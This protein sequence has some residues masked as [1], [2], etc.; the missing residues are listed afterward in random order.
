MLTLHI[1]NGAS[2]S[3]TLKHYFEQNK[4]DGTNQVLC[5]DDYLAIGPL[6]DG[7]KVNDHQLLN[8]RANYLFDM[9]QIA[10]LEEFADVNVEDQWLVDITEDISK[11][12]HFD[13]TPYH[14][15]VI[16][17]GDNAPERSLLYL[18]CHIIDEHKLYH[19]S[20]NDYNLSTH[21]LRGVGD[22]SLEMLDFLHNQEKKIYPVDCV[23]YSQLWQTL[24]KSS[25]R[26]DSL[27]RIFESNEVKSVGEDY[28]DKQILM[29]CQEQGQ[30]QGQGNF[31]LM[32]ALVGR[33]LGLSEQL[34]TDTFIIARVYY[35]IQN[36]S[37]GY[38]GDLDQPR[39]LQVRVRD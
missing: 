5:F 21:M 3:G 1:V 39:Q 23:Q 4:L 20:I 13:F 29:R 25:K 37:L 35:L 10:H 19:I 2:A 17:H 30:G 34:I 24:V 27:L 38:Q 8:Q 31:V 11:L 6:Y 28:F 12:C 33:V 32:M 26:P 22:C 36:T 15:V 9:L 18:C 14:K 7:N 16:W